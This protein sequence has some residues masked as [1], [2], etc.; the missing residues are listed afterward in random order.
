MFA[1]SYFWPLIVPAFL[2]AVWAALKINPREERGQGL[3]FFAILITLLVGGF[4]L[5]GTVQILNVSEHLAGGVLD[6]AAL[7]GAPEERLAGVA[8]WFT[9]AA[10]EDGAAERM[11]QRF[12]AAVGEVGPYAREVVLPSFWMGLK[13]VHVAPK[14]IES[15]EIG[16]GIGDAPAPNRYAVWVKARFGDELLW[17]ELALG[18]APFEE[19]KRQVEALRSEK[20]SRLLVD[21]R[22]FRVP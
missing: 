13:G 8:L 10:A 16:A 12:D 1:F 18:E 20:A 9:E 11:L 22:L 6:A 21:V 17:V 14:G 2:F 7:E 15:R 19:Q 3:V 5:F 4:A